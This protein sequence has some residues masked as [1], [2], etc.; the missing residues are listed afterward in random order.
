MNRFFI[1]FLGLIGGVLGVL[2]VIYSFYLRD[3][4]R[5]TQAE[6]ASESIFLFSVFATIGA[7]LSPFKPKVGGWFMMISG[8]SMIFTTVY[9][10]IM[11]VLSLVA[12]IVAATLCFVRNENNEPS[13]EKRKPTQRKSTS[14][15]A[16]S[17]KKSIQNKPVQKTMG[18]GN[19]GTATKQTKKKTTPPI[20]KPAKGKMTP[21]TKKRTPKN[22]AL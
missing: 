19:K 5:L 6:G 13:K 18:T 21:S 22:K 3:F 1:M 9:S 2:G 20:R 14:K 7:L 10:G 15:V 8:I 12:I 4:H 16:N 17:P 11:G